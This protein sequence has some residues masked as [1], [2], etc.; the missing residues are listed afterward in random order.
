MRLVGLFAP[1]TSESVDA[2]E[3]GAQCH[4]T[5]ALDTFP[6]AHR[7]PC[8]GNFEGTTKRSGQGEWV[9]ASA[10]TYTSPARRSAV[11][12]DPAGLNRT[13]TRRR[14]VLL[15]GTRR[16]GRNCPEAKR[17]KSTMRNRDGIRYRSRLPPA[18]TAAALECQP[19]RF[20]P[21]ASHT[22]TD[23]PPPPLP[24]D[25]FSGLMSCACSSPVAEIDFTVGLLDNDHLLHLL[26]WVQIYERPIHALCYVVFEGPP[27]PPLLHIFIRGAIANP[28]AQLLRRNTPVSP[29]VDDPLQ[30][31][32]R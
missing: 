22:K 24:A 1:E 5:Y 23:S 19:Y 6:K 18:T 13:H 16:D 12:T 17:H 31:G 8:H 28:R 7:R 21:S 3:S 4:S 11:P 29:L 9:F 20:S 27:S 15:T 10:S 14:T 26:S 30:I 25:S 32:C 2:G